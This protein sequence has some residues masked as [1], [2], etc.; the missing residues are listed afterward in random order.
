MHAVKTYGGS[1]GIAPLVL[2]LNI[3]CNQVV[4]VMTGCFTAGERA[5]GTNWLWGWLG[6]QGLSWCFAITEPSLA[7]GR[8]RTPEPPVH[9]LCT[10]LTG[11]P[12]SYFCGCHIWHQ[13]E[14]PCIT[15]YLHTNCQTSVFSESAYCVTIQMFKVLP[16]K[17]ISLKNEMA[18]LK[19]ALRRYLNTHCQ[20]ICDIEIWII[21]LYQLYIMD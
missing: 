6:P 4:G 2:H 15:H 3:R 20:W 5:P 21:I 8:T 12:A 10:I 9:S 17:L 7:S 19:G 18:Q 11:V 1:R 14:F 16:W 13:W